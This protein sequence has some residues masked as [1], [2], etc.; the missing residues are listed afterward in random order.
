MDLHRLWILCLL[1]CAAGASHPA[2]AETRSLTLQECLERAIQYNLGLKVDRYGP[3][4]AQ[5]N[6]SLAY[7]GYDPM[8]T[9]RGQHDYDKT[10]GGLDADQRIIPPST[11]DTDA[12]SGGINGL[13]P[14]GMTYD[15]SAR[16]ANTTGD[17]GIFDPTNKVYVSDPFESSQG[18][19]QAGVTQPLLKNS[20]IDSTRLNITVAKQQLASAREFYRQRLIELISVV[21]D[22]YYDLV[23]A[24]ENVKVQ[25]KGLQLARQLLEENRKRVEVGALAPLDEKQAEAEVAAREADLVSAEQQLGVRENILRRAI[26]DDYAEWHQVDLIPAD[27]MTAIPQV[28]DLQDSWNKGL[29]M[30]P[31]VVQQWLTMEQRDIEL[32]YSKNQL[33]PQLDAF[34]SYG[35]S[36]SDVEFSGLFTQYG[37]GGQPFWSAGA[38]FSVPISNTGARARHR[39]AR[40]QVEQEVLSMKN[41]EQQIMAEID[42]AIKSAKGSF[43]KVQATRAARGYAEAALEAEQEKLANGKSTSFEVLRL[44]RDLTSARSSEISALTE[45][46]KTLVALAQFEG[47]TLERHAI[48][49]D[50]D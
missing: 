44:Q 2:Q 14:W 50:A 35:H 16:A 31:E 33:Y 13:L 21:E 25:E 40:A 36:G 42:D 34:A 4:F 3:V 46:N 12:L 32:K 22:A 24:R 5:N 37:D 17:R 27:A 1:C 19:V 45:Y 41:L 26:T 47:T 28:Y 7:A 38:V 6:L 43:R 15:L 9:F 29:T 39:N 30:R 48:N 10:G 49:L 18:Y 20:W 8:L 11:S 23:A